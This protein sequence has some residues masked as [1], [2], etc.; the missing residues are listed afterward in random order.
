MEPSMTASFF[1][2]G[3]PAPQGSKRHVGRGVMVES[4]EAV[5]PWRQAVA[6]EAKRQ[7][8]RFPAGMPVLVEVTFFRRRPKSA[9]KLLYPVTKPDGDKLLRAICDALETSGVVPHDAQIVD[10]VSRKRFAADGAAEGALIDISEMVGHVAQ[11]KQ[12]ENQA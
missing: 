6:V 4:S 12:E 7:P 2:T 5:R 8:V 10:H 3:T 9:K 1:V 11:T